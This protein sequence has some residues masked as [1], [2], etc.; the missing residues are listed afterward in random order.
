MFASQTVRDEKVDDD[1]GREVSLT[2]VCP[3]RMGGF[4][5]RLSTEEHM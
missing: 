5:V 3:N 4:V 2:C 1:A